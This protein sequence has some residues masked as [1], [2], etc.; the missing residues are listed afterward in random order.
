MGTG[1]CVGSQPVVVAG[2]GFIGNGM[3]RQEQKWQQEGEADK[4]SGEMRV[5]HGFTAFGKEIILT[6]LLLKG[7]G[8]CG[9]E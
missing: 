2:G 5:V 1:Y 7:S 9:L 6:C 3:C 8:I 4:E